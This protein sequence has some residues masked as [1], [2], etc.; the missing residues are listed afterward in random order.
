MRYVMCVSCLVGHLSLSNS[1]HVSEY[2]CQSVFVCAL[3]F[4]RLSVDR[5][6]FYS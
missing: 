5:L 3:T 6:N 2:F 4:R 1:C